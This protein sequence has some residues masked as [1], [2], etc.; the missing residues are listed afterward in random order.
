MK[1]IFG[2]AV[3]ACMM[4]A[5]NNSSETTTTANDTAT[6]A[7]ADTSNMM[8]TPATGDTL[9]STSS[10]PAYAPSEGDA[11][12]SNGSLMVY[13]NG[14]WTNS[15]ADVKLDN[16]VVVYKNGKVK[17][18]TK[19]V[20]LQDGE[21]VTRSGSFFDR[22]GNTISDG[23]DATKH[24][25]SEVGQG[26]KKGAEKAAEGVKKGAGEVKDVITGKDEH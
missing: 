10:N 2:F 20:T 14:S 16:D 24:G 15:D 1:K 6:M 22:A 12:Y 3:V 9:G 25:A 13:R 5:C 18:K 23:W 8:S 4:A 17:N 21:V 26:V 11:K 7:P 19:E